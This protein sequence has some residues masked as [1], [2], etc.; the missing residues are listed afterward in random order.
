M[1]QFFDA[2]LLLRTMAFHRK[3]LAMIEQL[4]KAV[5]AVFPAAQMRVHR[6]GGTEFFENGKELGHVH[7]NGLLDVRV[8]R[9]NAA[10]LIFQGKAE[11]HHIFKNS[12][13]VSFW[14]RNESDVA[15]A[16]ALL[17]IARQR[18]KDAR[19]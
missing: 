18:R 1:P 16:L 14:L 6:F 13:F 19:A 17:Q 4:E 9:R 15:S 8:G 12:G 5:P 7:G 10:E 3:R 11:P 2:A